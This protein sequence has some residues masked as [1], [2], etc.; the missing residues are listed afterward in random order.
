M[1]PNN[2]PGTIINFENNFQPRSLNLTLEMSIFAMFYC[3]KGFYYNLIA[4]DNLTKHFIAFYF[5]KTAN[6]D[7]IFQKFSTQD[8]Y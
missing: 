4:K 8:D 7:H 3:K 1:V 5:T 2:R 6:L